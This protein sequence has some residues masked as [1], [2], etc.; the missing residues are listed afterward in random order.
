MGLDNFKFAA[1]T[2]PG[3][4]SKMCINISII[5]DELVERT[6]KLVICLNTTQPTADSDCT[7]IYIEDNDG[8]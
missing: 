7:D 5:D 6:E 3:S 8:M 4:E 1:G 2:Q